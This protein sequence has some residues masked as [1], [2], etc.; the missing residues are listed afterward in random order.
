MRKPESLV[1][2]LLVALALIAGATL[3]L[4]NLRGQVMGG[5]ELH[6]VR[7]ALQR[8][9][10]GILFTYQVSDNCIPLTLFDRLVLDAGWPLSEMVVRLPVLVA[11][12]AM[13]VLGPWWAWRRLG[14]GPA[15]VF[16][17]L[18]ALSPALV[19]YSRV[20]RSYMPVA[21]LG[22]AALAAFDA[23]QRRG[24]WRF[25]TA[26]VVCAAAAVWFHLGAVP[27]VLAPLLAALPWALR[28]RG[29]RVWALVGVAAAIAAA[30]LVLLVPARETLPLVAG[31][32][33]S[34]ELSAATIGETAVW[35]A[36][37]RWW[38]LAVPFGIAVVTGAVRLARREPRLATLLAVTAVG[39]VVGI[40]VLAP[41]GHQNPIIMARYLVPALPIA[42]AFAAEALGR[43]WFGGWRRAH[44]ALA[45]LAIVALV[46]ASPFTDP[47]LRHSSFA[48]SVTFLRFTDE[49]PAL[50]ALPALPAEGP[51]PVYAWLASAAPGAIVELPWHPVWR[52]D[53]AVGLYQTVHRRPVIVTA[54][55]GP[56]ADRRLAFRNM[57]RTDAESLLRS[58]G[59]WLVVHR[60]L[61]AEEER[62][63]PLLVDGRVR[64]QLRIAGPDAARR[65]R[66][67]WGPPDY[68]DDR[69]WCWDLDRVRRQPT[70]A[71][72]P[73]R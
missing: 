2:A 54:F 3:R 62:I 20:A 43:P 45:A 48:H 18:L 31:K 10:S 29:R 35:L 36:G 57:V 63:G 19:V 40:L 59:R 13:L 42:L 69:T 58:R 51:P 33:G 26:Y 44:P 32:R 73:A 16:A 1:P 68:R 71:T 7:A 17:W 15:V 70:P 28:E 23:W 67:V 49:R 25:A 6:A 38:W 53:R 37:V 61:P 47:A 39:Q 11:G 65:L 8:P 4:W 60:S 12:L 22:C 50:P 46:T 14:P 24:G 55:G 52:F 56:L 9:V 27:L 66:T 72:T 5:D 30:L 21:L 34:L 41:E 64:Y